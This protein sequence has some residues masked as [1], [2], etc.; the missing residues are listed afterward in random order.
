M[1]RAARVAVQE[2][3]RFWRVYFSECHSASRCGY[4]HGS[5]AKLRAA[6]LAELPRALNQ[7]L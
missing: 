5:R 3:Y 7:L 6:R 1:L 4:H 2:E